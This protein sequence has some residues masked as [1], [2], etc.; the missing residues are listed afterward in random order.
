MALRRRLA[1][2]GLVIATWSPA[3]AE[4]PVT[5]LLKPLDLISYTAG[6]KPPRFDGATLDTRRLSLDDLGGKVVVVNFWASWCLECRPE[7]PMLERLHREL[8]PR[9]LAVVGVNAREGPGAVRRYARELGL[10]FPLV[11]DAGGAI[12]RAYGVI[13]L[14]TTFMVARD[15]RAVAF[16]VGPREW[17]SPPAHAL[18]E[19]LLAEPTPR[20]P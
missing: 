5:T 8:G 1:A 7:M 11:L 12:N 16:A 9:G 2:C 3:C 10:S 18:I 13:G 4:Q 20:A 19:R 6:T 14:P 17:S 15:G